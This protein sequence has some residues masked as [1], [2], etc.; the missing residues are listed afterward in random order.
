MRS[1]VITG[2][3]AEALAL[4]FAVAGAL[5]ALGLS[6]RCWAANVVGTLFALGWA[7][8]VRSVQ[9]GPLLQTP[10]FLLMFLEAAG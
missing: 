7:L 10:I 1:L 6:G 8:R 3:D 2:W 9:A 4:A 5:V